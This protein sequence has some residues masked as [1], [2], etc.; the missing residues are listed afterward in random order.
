M[1]DAAVML[2]LVAVAVGALVSA[3]LI[4][5]GVDCA[6]GWMLASAGAAAV[7]W[8]ASGGEP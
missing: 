1:R 7:A 8:G 5:A 2:G 3:A 6:A 4:L